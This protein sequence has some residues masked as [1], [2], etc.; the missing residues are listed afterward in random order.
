MVIDLNASFLI[1]LGLILLLLL[2]LKHLIF[3]PYLR[4][5][6]ARFERTTAQLQRAQALHDRAVALDSQC[7]EQLQAARVKA[8]SERSQLLKQA[9]KEREALLAQAQKEGEDRMAEA[10]ERMEAQIAEARREMEGE[11]I[12]LAQVIRSKFL[13]GRP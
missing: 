10:R 4:M 6:D 13:G 3:E 11:A 5:K 1:Q 2:L 9:A 8:V 12:A 7:R